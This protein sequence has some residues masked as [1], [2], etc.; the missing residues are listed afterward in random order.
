VRYSNRVFPKEKKMSFAENRRV[1]VFWT[2]GSIAIAIQP[3][4]GH[5]NPLDTIALGEASGAIKEALTRGA[6]F[7]VDRLG[8]E[9]GF[10]K[11]AALK[12]LLPD[13]IRQAE[14]LLRLA[15]QG[16]ELDALVV[17]MNRAAERAV[18]QARQMLV[19]AA[20]S[21]TVGDAK[22]ILTGGDTS[23]TDFFR[24]KTSEALTQK[25]LPVVSG[26]IGRLGLAQ[27]YNALMSQ[28]AQLRL[29]KPE[30]ASL[31]RHVTVKALDGLYALI[32][33]QERNLRS[34]P[35]QAGSKLLERVFGAMR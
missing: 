25:F 29:L 6:N 33:Q 34:N 7:A 4:Q 30:Q 19:S 22:G 11:D 1:R 18:P 24:S 13:P 35:V 32:G 5:A 26:V 15:G 21:M 16:P 28:A 9:D 2:L 20:Q 23:V 14:K 3:R 8:V 31:E 12:I 10:L 27:R 17:A